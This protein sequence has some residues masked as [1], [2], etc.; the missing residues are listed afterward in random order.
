MLN[1]VKILP[2]EG[3][4]VLGQIHIQNIG[5][6]CGKKQLLIGS[7]GIHHKGENGLLHVA[8]DVGKLFVAV[9]KRIAALDE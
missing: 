7:D 2:Q 3:K 5:V 1:I 6:V 8:V 4:S 9:V